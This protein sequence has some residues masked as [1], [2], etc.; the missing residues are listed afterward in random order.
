MATGRQGL[1]EHGQRRSIRRGRRTV[2]RDYGQEEAASSRRRA[3]GTAGPFQGPRADR[4]QR[5]PPLTPPGEL[6][7]RRIRRTAM[8]EYTAA[9]RRRDHATFR[10]RANVSVR[11]FGPSFYMPGPT[12]R[13]GSSRVANDRPLSDSFYHVTPAYKPFRAEH[14]FLINQRTFFLRNGIFFTN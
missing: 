11:C 12:D 6:R 2:L 7:A 10:E 9:S 14:V 4:E 8:P 13:Q 5:T 3:V 1:L